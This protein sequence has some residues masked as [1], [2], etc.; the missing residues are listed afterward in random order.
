MTF[1][2]K[3]SDGPFAEFKQNKDPFVR[4]VVQT[5]AKA[6][7][8]LDK[9]EPLIRDIIEND[10]MDVAG[11]NRAKVSDVI[12]AGDET[13]KRVS[14]I[15]LK[16]IKTVFRYLRDNLPQDVLIMGHTLAAWAKA[17]F[18]D[19]THRI[20]TAISIGL[21]GGEDN[22]DIAHRV[23]G[24]RRLFGADGAT[25]ITRRHIVRLGS[26]LIKRT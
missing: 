23:V 6:I 15:R 5:F 1:V 3:S 8:M 7:S 12:I 24:G 20:A 26:S 11:I 10:L 16:S 4:H 25:E 21:T 14:A 17:I 2:D 9:S 19:D 18:D 22:T 13:A